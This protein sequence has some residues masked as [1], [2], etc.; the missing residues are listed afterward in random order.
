MKRLL[1]ALAL[2]A[3]SASI[4]PA[5][6]DARFIMANGAE[7]QTLDPSLIRN[8][9]EHRIYLALFEGLVTS[10][11]RTCRALPGVAESWSMNDDFTQITFT[12]REALWSDGE[13]ITAQTVVD[14]WIRTLT[15]STA[16][17][18][19]YRISMLVKG[20][21]DYNVGIAG[22]EAVQLRAL[23]ERTFQV[24]LEAPM[25]YAVDMMAQHAFAILPMHAIRRHGKEWANPDNL[26]TNGPY[27]LES[28]TRNRSL[29][30][31][32]NERYW[33]AANV[34]LE[35]IAFLPTLESRTAFNLYTQGTVDWMHG[36]PLDHLSEI[37]QRA[38]YQVWP[39]IAPYYYV[40]NMT[41]PP[42][43]DLRVRKALAMA[44]D[45]KALVRDATKGGQAPAD[46]LVPP[47]EGYDPPAGIPYSPD[48]AR[49]LLADAGFPGGRGFPA[50][51]L[52][53]DTTLEHELIANHLAARW[54]KELG[55]EVTPK[56]K[57]WTIFL[58]HSE[59]SHDFD[60]THSGRAGD[61]PDPNA[62]LERFL[63]DTSFNEGLY[64]S[65]AYDE[66][67]A[68]ASRMTQGAE[69]STTLRA[70]ESLLI[71]EDAA[72]IPLYHHVEQ[73]LIDLSRWEGWYP[74]AL[75]VHPWKFIRR[76][77]R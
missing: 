46:A 43:T 57:E 38:D 54:K 74:N 69:R 63:R 17:D 16:A 36:I 2:A 30:V 48:Q 59:S 60:I 67:V 71:R 53:H 3:H 20:A 42:F 65:E 56:K 1:V 44:I 45:K 27:R 21:T 33:D 34:E 7:P 28:W 77:V 15:P 12:L 70:A 19:A 52:L 29:L 37:V 4:V 62:M 66:L 10:D 14:S 32:K 25:P 9:S 8:A 51:S 55:I 6:A 40:F 23:D 50:L 26:V 72:I 35:S 76:A 73:D 68:R 39:S 5:Q 47:L 13:P 31:V 61:Y 41:R 24:D 58:G 75:G 22:A 49:L 64:A 11:P 18:Y